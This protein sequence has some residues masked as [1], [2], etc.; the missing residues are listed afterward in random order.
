MMRLLALCGAVFAAATVGASAQSPVERGGYLVN[1]I[2]GCSNCHTPRGP[3][4]A[5][6]LQ[7]DKRLSGSTQTFQAPQY[8]VKGSNLTPDA[9]TGLGSWTDAQI[10]AAITTGKRRDG[11]QLVP[12]MPSAV[13]GLLTERDQDAIVAYLRSIPA[14][15]NAVQPPEYKAAFTI[16]PFPDIKPMADADLNDPVKRGLYL[17]ALGHCVVCHSRQTP[18]GMDYVNGLGAGGRKFGPQQAVTA[19][20]L[21]SKGVAAWSDAE[22]KRALVDGVSKDGRKLN[23][24][25]VDFAQYYKTMTDADIGA[26]IAWM[27]SLKPVD[28]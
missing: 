26:L 27:R 1:G 12:N 20:N 15:K 13:Y 22:I 24:P 5:T 3:G 8:T 23:A 28:M 25:M 6:D 2:G 11:V 10:K 14:I 17:A 16:S 21:T 4:G 7:L 19:A 9:E 18:A